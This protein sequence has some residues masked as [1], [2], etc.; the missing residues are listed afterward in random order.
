MRL[1]TKIKGCF[2]RFLD[3]YVFISGDQGC[4]LGS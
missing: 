1:D 3:L 2:Y 4:L